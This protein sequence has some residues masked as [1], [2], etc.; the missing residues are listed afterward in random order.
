MA[1]TGFMTLGLLNLV[2][3]EALVTRVNV[4]R[5]STALRVADSIRVENKG[6]SSGGPEAPIDYRYL[7][8]LDAD[9]AAEVV[10]ALTAPVV[11]PADSPARAA[12]VKARCQAVE[13]LF[14]R[15][16]GK[17]RDTDW[18]RWNVS[19]WR[20][21]RA[22]EGQEASLRKVTCLDA[23]GERAFGDRDSRR[24][25]PGEQWY[26]PPSAGASVGRI[27]F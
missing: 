24:A 2:N 11:A 5:A 17:S 6:G 19:R 23:D 26:Q 25:R 20:A 1:I 3:H 14:D 18:R 12:E 16:I 7:T 15:W 21:R 10:R 4:A 8:R 9:G 27:G 13:R 22:I